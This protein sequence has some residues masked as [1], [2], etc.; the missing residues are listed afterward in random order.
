VD[1]SGWSPEYSL[2][3]HYGFKGDRALARLTRH[4]ILKEDHFLLT[5][6]AVRDFFFARKKQILII[7]GVVAAVLLLSFGIYYYFAYSSEKTHE[8][9]SAA[10]TIYQASVGAVPAPGDTGPSFKTPQEKYEKALA[11]FK[12]VAQQSRLSTPGKIAGYYAGLCLKQLNRDN[13]AITQLE[14][15]S[16][17]K[18]DYGALSLVALA[19]LY[20]KTGNLSKAA[21]LYQQIVSDDM[22][23]TPKSVALMHLAQLQEQLNKTAEAVKTYQQLIKDFSDSPYTAKAE[24]RIKQIAK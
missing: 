6:E 2:S 22:Y 14:P 11:E 9:L 23:V 16:K 7:A 1:E 12:K 24:E 17:E 8:E 15:L 20:E 13:E 21:E 3:G 18:S 10:L 19:S 5:M 4:E